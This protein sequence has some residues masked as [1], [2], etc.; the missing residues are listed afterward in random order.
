MALRLETTDITNLMRGSTSVRKVMHGTVE[1]WVSPIPQLLYLPI[2][3]FTTGNWI[4]APL[5]GKVNAEGNDA[6]LISDNQTAT[7]CSLNLTALGTPSV[8]EL[9][10]QFRARKSAAGGNDRTLQM[11]VISN[12]ATIVTSPA[13]SLTENWTDYSYTLAGARTLQS[14]RLNLTSAGSTGGSAGVKRAVEVA[15]VRLIA[16]PA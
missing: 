16:T 10:Y 13:V 15:F 2:S 11:S 1:V 5:W 14:P 8:T 12:S 7:S 4:T 9:T 6:T 3:D